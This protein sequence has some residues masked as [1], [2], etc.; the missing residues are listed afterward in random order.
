MGLTPNRVKALLDRLDTDERRRRVS[1]G[2][3]ENPQAATM[4]PGAQVGVLDSFERRE[5]C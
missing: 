5:R 3:D 4:L 2:P 1:L